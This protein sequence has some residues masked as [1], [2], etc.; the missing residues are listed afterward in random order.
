MGSAIVSAILEKH[1]DCNVTIFD[2]SSSISRVSGEKLR[3]QNVRFV[4]GD[5]EDI[6][7]VRRG[8]EVGLKEMREE[9]EKG[10]NWEVVIHTAGIVPPLRERYH[11]RVQKE[12]WKTNVEGTKNV[13]EVAREMGI[14]GL[15]Y[16]SSCCE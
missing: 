1:P 12:V 6:E 9:N 7:S 11:R 3:R 14:G 10:G 15:V 8:F 5:I 4:E 16:T 2:L 13:L